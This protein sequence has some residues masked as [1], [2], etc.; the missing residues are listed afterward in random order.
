M[1]HADTIIHAGAILTVNS[2]F[3]VLNK[4]A[5]VITDGKISAILPSDSP[6]LANISATETFHL[7][8][9]VLMPG[10]INAHGHAPMTL[11]RGWADDYALMTW[12]ND[13]IWP[14]ESQFVDAKFVREGTELAIAEMIRGGT[15]FYSD[16]YFFPEAAAKV[17][18]QTGMRMQITSPVFDFP[19][20]WGSGPDDYLAKAEALLDTYKHTD[21]VHVVLGPHAPYTVSDEPLKRI[22]ALAD[23]YQTGIQIHLHETAFEV[24]TAIKEHGERPVARMQKLGLLDDKFQAV[25]MTT[26]NDTDIRMIADAGSHVIHC[27]ESNM[28]LASGF[29]PTQKLQQANINIAI[30]TDGAASNNDLDMFG[31]MRTTALLAKASALEP[32]V[33]TAPE[34]IAMAT[35][36]GARAMGLGDKTGS[37]ELGKYADIIAL[38]LSG[39][40]HQPIYDLASHIVYTNVS[41]TVTHSW[42]NGKLLLNNRQ[43]TQMNVDKIKQQTLAWREKIQEFKTSHDH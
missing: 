26:L 15:T 2:A 23:N 34:A 8:N 6:T 38:D 28:K 11:F 27:P 43:L 13:Y 14:A 4:H 33:V 20:N 10:L 29:T 21:L 41:N 32:T 1:Q 5:L 40:E 36:N 35:I 12:L 30:G 19:C 18:E 17:A 39:I 3:D 9:H 31:E 37:L 22:R 24:E 16:M 42:V 25:H 7:N